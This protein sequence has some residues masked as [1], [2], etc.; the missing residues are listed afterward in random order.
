MK[1]QST[2][3]GFAILSMATIIQK[4]LSLL[5]VPFL[6]KILGGSAP[7]GIYYAAY[8]IYAFIFVLTNAGI[9][10]AI[11][12]LVS[13]F[14]AVKNYKDAVKSFKLARFVLIIIGT[15]MSIMLFALARPLAGLMKMP[16][17]SLAVMALGPS[18][19]CTSVS[20]AYRGYFQ[21]RGNMTPTAVSQLLEQIVNTTL[22]LVFAALLLRYGVEAACAGATVGTTFGALVSAIYLIVTY[23]KNKHFRIPK[24]YYEQAKR[25]HSSKQILRKIANYGVPITL[26]IG[27]QNAG[28]LVDTGNTKSRLLAGGFADD[29]ATGLFGMLGQY[30]T[31][32]NVPI[33]IISTLSVTILPAI[34]AA[35]AVKDKRAL[36][37]RINYAFRVCFL[38]AIPSAVGFSIMSLPIYKVIYPSTSAGFRIMFLGSFILVLMSLV[39]IQTSILQG[40][41][42]IYNVTIYSIIGIVVKIVT[43]YILIAIPT[44]NVYGTIIGSFLGFSTTIFLNYRLMKKS[45]RVKFGMLK[46]AVKPLI[47]SIIMGG[48]VCIVYTVINLAL[49]LVIK[50]AYFDNLVAFVFAV[51][52]G[53]FVYIACLAI[54]RGIRKSDLDSFPSKI[55]KLIPRPIMELIK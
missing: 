26:C 15:I 16:K 39:Q 27:M 3:K 22:S 34:S 4:I 53:V 55:R 9:P 36:S 25:K 21:G 52:A 2:A 42:K 50:K 54:T 7:Y 43:N 35:V 28:N 49:T 38:I 10:V 47:S 17:A 13:E 41:G 8:Q 48:A 51:I 18:I 44:I 31:L 5:Y 33:A 45:M 11:S 32:M 37:N 46:H 12:K 14:V 6:V 1:E 40:I 29:K 24:E 23:E 30:Q 19:F 20:S